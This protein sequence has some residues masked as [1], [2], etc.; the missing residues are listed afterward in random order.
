MKCIIAGLLALSILGGCAKTTG[1]SLSLSKKGDDAKIEGGWNA[2][3]GKAVVTVTG[4]YAKNDGTPEE[5]TA[6]LVLSFPTDQPNN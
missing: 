5:Y 1:A 3:F 4:G 6:G 2:Q